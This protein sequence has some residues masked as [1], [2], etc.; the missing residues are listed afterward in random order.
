MRTT[1]TLDDDV[2]AALERLRKQ[3]DSSYRDV[4]ND[5]MR[6]GLR[7]ALE[8]REPAGKYVTPVSDCGACLIGSLDNLAEVLA[9]AEGED[10]R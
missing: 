4:V 2:A 5:V 10:Y 7:H 3:R 1:L 9:I 8:V 6:R